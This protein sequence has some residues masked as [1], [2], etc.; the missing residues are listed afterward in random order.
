[1]S[2]LAPYSAGCSRLAVSLGDSSKRYGGKANVY[3]A[4]QP[5]VDGKLRTLRISAQSSDRQEKTLTQ[6]VMQGRRELLLSG[7]SLVCGASL[8]PTKTWTVLKL[9][10]WVRAAFPISSHANTNDR[11]ELTSALIVSVCEQL[12]G[13]LATISGYCGGKEQNPTYSLVSEG[14]TGHAESL[15]VSCDRLAFDALWRVMV[16]RAALQATTRPVSYNGRHTSCRVTDMSS[17]CLF[18]LSFST[19]IPNLM[20]LSYT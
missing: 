5:K 18:V 6:Q 15:A 10:S 8:I 16:F 20:I 17:C 9:T 2:A 11:G 12:E 13:V 4:I 3:S 7:I 19:I 1:M 14:K